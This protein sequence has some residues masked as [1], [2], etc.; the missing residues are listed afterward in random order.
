MFGNISM[1]TTMP[2]LCK[3]VVISVPSRHN[4]SVNLK[5]QLHSRLLSKQT[6]RIKRNLHI[7]ASIPPSLITSCIATAS[8]IVSFGFT[9]PF[10]TCKLYMQM[11]KTW[12]S[13]LDLYQGFSTFVMISTFQCFF[14][15]N[16]FFALLNILQPKLPSHLAFFLASFISSFTTSFVKVP[17]TFIS[18]NIVFIKHKQGLDAVQYILQL[19]TLEVFKKSWMSNMLSDV[20]DTFVKFFVNSYIQLNMIFIGTFLRSCITGAITSVVNAPLDFMVTR[21][22]CQLQSTESIDIIEKVDKKSDCLS[23]LQYRLIA[24]MIGNVVFFNVFNKL[25]IFMA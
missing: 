18:R 8:K 17:T 1:H 24:S 19:L 3:K 20:P 9:Y 25:S 23:G 22:M 10:E 11:G 4:K 16:V 6:K 15:Y 2:P 13:P 21:T 5:K 12:N 7:S 14:N